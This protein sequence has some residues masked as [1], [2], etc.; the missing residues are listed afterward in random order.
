[1]MCFRVLICG[2][3]VVAGWH[4]EQALGQVELF[5]TPQIN[6]VGSEV[7]YFGSL[8][9]NGRLV[10]D[11]NNGFFDKGAFRAIGKH[12][13]PE[14]ERLLI[15]SHFEGLQAAGGKSSGEARWYL[16]K[17]NRGA[18][19]LTIFFDVP[20]S[21]VGG[22]WKVRVGK[23]E[24]ELATSVSDGRKPQ[25]IVMPLDAGSL[26]LQIISI[27][28][29]GSKR[30]SETKFCKMEA[31]GPGIDGA[32]LI[33]AR[34]RPAAVHARYE[35]SQCKEPKLW[36]FETQ[37]VRQSSSYSPITT[38]FGY[39]GASFNAEGLS[40]GGINFSMW[41]ANRN[42]AKLPPVSTMPHLLATANPKAEFS[43]FG[44]EGSG[45]KIRNWDPY[46]RH[47]KSVIQALRV[48][49]AN[50]FDT[51]YGYLFDEY[52]KRWMLFAAGR[53]PSKNKR[54]QLGLRAGSFCE[55]PGPPNV[56]R[57]GDVVREVK[58]RGWAYGLDKKW[59]AADT[60]HLGDDPADTSR[61]VR[62]L[63]EG[64]LSMGTGGVEMTTGPKVVRLREQPRPL[65]IY[66][67]P[68]YESQLFEL[69]VKIG[70]P[71]VVRIKEGSAVV[72][73]P[74][75]QAGSQT[76]AT[77]Y[78]GQS[79]CLTFVKRKLHNTEKKG[80]SSEQ[81]NGDRTWQLQTAAVDVKNA[82]TEFVLDGLSPGTTYY[83]R[84]LVEGSQGK[85]WAFKTGQFTT[86]A[87]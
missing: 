44:H 5:S 4:A 71:E 9:I 82:S 73:Y 35:S 37:S 74:G 70:N 33:R 61:F 27:R 14:S 86:N 55:V 20:R 48:E 19:E 28:K 57:T 53:R 87:N 78:Y 21:E 65:P 49:S 34:W 83:F 17:T 15:S 51:F 26:G 84:V 13:S 31:A 3:L 16:W 38:A 60:L 47:P 39:F 46:L 52:E 41:A 69:P 79:D 25:S 23:D 58:R 43:G 10:L 45:V 42:A 56:E 63:D 85:S 7:S 81:F 59:H 6:G 75:L 8:P 24:F 36:V 1:M 64:W 12:P 18:A 68:K 80:A 29:L 62:V 66:L 67:K 72:I 50:G 2:V 76:Q 77:L 30:S 32:R 54:G 40:A 11:A 22:T